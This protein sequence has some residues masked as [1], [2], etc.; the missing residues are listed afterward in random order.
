MPWWRFQRWRMLYAGVVALG[1]LVAVAVVLASTGARQASPRTTADS[2][3]ATAA[4]VGG[5]ASPTTCTRRPAVPAW[6]SGFETGN[7][8]E[9]TQWGQGQRNWYP[10]SHVVDPLGEGIP[11]RQGRRVA[12]FA[13]SDQDAASGRIH[14]KVYKAWRGPPNDVSGTYRAWFYV[15]RS[16]RFR[17]NSWG[18]NIFQW[19]EEYI[20]KRGR[21][22]QDPE[23]VVGLG[24]AH[25]YGLRGLPRRAPVVSVWTGRGGR[26]SGPRRFPLGKWVEVCADLFDGQ[27]IDVYLNGRLLAVA[28]ARDF[29][30]GPSQGSRSLKWIFGVGNYGSNSGPIYVDAVSYLRF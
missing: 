29:P 21:Y 16:Y 12:R 26:V 22:R 5:W 4:R 9:W 3:S 27:K 8:R 28:R 6:T 23:W 17:A 18:A 15:P 25:W 11:R 13:V 19:K 2:A 30:V 1:S 7:F 10:F 20:D 24:P 14:A